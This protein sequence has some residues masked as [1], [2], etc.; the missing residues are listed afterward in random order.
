VALGRAAKKGVI[1][2]NVA[3]DADPPRVVKKERPTLDL[4]G[5]K[6]FFGVANGERLEALWIRGTFVVGLS[7]V[8]RQS[9]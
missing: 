7:R 6:R 1:P 4:G 5:L 2:H 8:V 3:R 9:L